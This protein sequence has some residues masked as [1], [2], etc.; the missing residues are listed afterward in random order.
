LDNDFD[1]YAMR[2]A[3]KRTRKFLETTP[4]LSDFTIRRYGTQVPYGNTDD[5]TDGFIRDFTGTLWHPSS[6]CPMA[7]ASSQDGVIDPQHRVKGVN[8]LRIVDL[9]IFP[10]NTAGHPTGMLYAVAERASDLI[11]NT[12]AIESQTGSQVTF[13]N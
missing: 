6:T 13:G 1:M 8:G 4:S 5:G 11:K 7:K 3:L 10:N 9:S 2:R 12:Y